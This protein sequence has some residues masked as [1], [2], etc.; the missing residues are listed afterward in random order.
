VEGSTGMAVPKNTY[1]PVDP[2]TLTQR[3]RDTRM[4]NE[5]GKNMWTKCN[6]G[7]VAGSMNTMSQAKMDFQY[8]PSEI[9]PVDKKN[10]RRRDT[11]TNYV[12]AAAKYS[13]I[14]KKS[15]GSGL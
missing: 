10:F 3:Q 14:M 11:F 15:G 9:E 5:L 8:D 1:K 7:Y 4:A 12:E 6:P 13:N 2:S